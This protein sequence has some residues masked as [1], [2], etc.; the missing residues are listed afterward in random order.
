MLFQN[1]AY[2]QCYYPSNC[3]TPFT[4]VPC[5]STFLVLRDIQEPNLHGKWYIDDEL[6][7]LNLYELWFQKMVL[8]LSVL[9]KWSTTGLVLC[10]WE[11]S[12]HKAASPCVHFFSALA[13]H[14][15]CICV[16]KMPPK[17]FQLA[18]VSM[19][20]AALSITHPSKKLNAAITLGG[21][22]VRWT[23][24][25]GRIRHCTHGYMIGTSGDRITTACDARGR[26]MGRQP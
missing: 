19:C 18:S 13:L 10:D 24:F 3:T 23:L 16:K 17:S 8:G 15:L 2:A 7:N 1:S 14:L 5:R 21:N 11:I 12:N 22:F 26:E 9:G 25:D 4:R 20:P 6:N